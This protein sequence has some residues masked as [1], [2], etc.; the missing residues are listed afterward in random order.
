LNEAQIRYC[1]S[2]KIRV[3]AWKEG[4]NNYSQNS[5]DEFNTA[6]ADYNARCSHFRY[7]SGS[8]ESVRAQVEVNRYKIRSQGIASAL[9]N[10]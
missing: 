9:A 4:V 6:V 3:S 7:R 10:P 8:L 5:V 2:E 1:L